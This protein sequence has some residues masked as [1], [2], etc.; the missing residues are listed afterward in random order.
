MADAAAAEG[1]GGVSKELRKVF[2][3]P[4]IKN[5]DMLVE[6]S[7]EATEIVTTAVDKY[8]NSANY[9]AAARTIKDAM[10]KKFGPAWQVC[11]GEGFGFG[12]TYQQ[13]NML[14]LFYGGASG[15]SKLGIL[16][17]KL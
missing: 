3:K 9:E 13:R 8:A 7:T 1:E 15:E 14:Y 5:C 2:K 4:L 17:Y 10:D 16:L 6:L 11:I 12:I